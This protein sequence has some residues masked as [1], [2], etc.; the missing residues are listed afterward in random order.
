MKNILSLLERLS[1]AELTNFSLLVTSR[2]EADIRAVMSK[3]ATHQ[4]DLHAVDSQKQD[5]R[6]YVSEVLLHDHSFRNWR[7]ERLI[8]LAVS[9]LSEKAHG[10]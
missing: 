10:M 8:E 4:T 5:L 9:T 3:L 1:K 2:P 6:L 7:D